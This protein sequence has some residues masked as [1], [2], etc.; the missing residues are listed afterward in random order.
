MQ[1]NIH[2]DIDSIYDLKIVYYNR[3]SFFRALNDKFVIL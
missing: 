3:M 2:L 1:F